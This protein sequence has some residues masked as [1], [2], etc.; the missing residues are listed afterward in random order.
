MSANAAEARAAWLATWSTASALLRGDREGAA[1][2]VDG[3][4]SP[5]V[6]RE[7]AEALARAL[8]VYA[9]NSDT[10]PRQVQQYVTDILESLAVEAV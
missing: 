6:V 8:R 1:Y 9:V 3:S 2:L 7:S 10:S 5:A 4:E